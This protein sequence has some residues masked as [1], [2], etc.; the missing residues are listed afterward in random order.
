MRL[1]P[2]SSFHDMRMD[3][4]HAART[5]LRTQSFVVAVLSL[6]LAVGATTAVYVTADWLLNRSPTGV[7]EPERLVG[8][9]LAEHGRPTEVKFGFSYPQYN[10]LREVQDAFS[11]VAAYAKVVRVIGDDDW[12]D[13]VVIQFVSGS[14]FPLLGVRPFLGHLQG[15]EDDLDGAAPLAVLSHAFWRSH[16]GADPDVVGASFR[17]GVDEARIIGV[18]GPDF[19]DYS[20]DWNG[21]TQVWLPMRS[22][23]G[24]AGMAGMLTMNQTFFRVMGRLA[25]G[26]DLFQAGE[27][28]Q[29]WV[30]ELPAVVNSLFDANAIA[31]E[32]EREMRIARRDQAKA[33]LGA[34]FAVN[35]LVLL[36]ACVNVVNL[37]LGR[38]A[39]RKKEMAIRAALGASWT[40]MLRQALTEA[41]LLAV[42]VGCAATGL[43]V[44]L[45]SLLGSLPEVYLDLSNRTDPLTTSGAVDL[46]MVG[47]AVAIGFVA[48][49]VL[50][51]LPMLSTFR[52]PI[53]AIKRCPP[54]WSLSRNRPSLR[55]GLLVLQVGLATVL[56]I[57]GGLFARSSNGA[58]NVD[59]EYAFPESV[60]L[61]RLVPVG[62][63][64]DE[65]APFFHS[66]MDALGDMP[67]VVSAALSHNPPFAGGRS[68]VGLPDDPEGSFA[69]GAATAGPN[70]FETNGIEVLA[71][72]EFTWD[73]SDAQ[74]AVV[75]EVAARRL[76]PREDPVGRVL[77]F[78]GEPARVIGLV[79]RDR[80]QDPLDEPTPCAWRQPRLV[81]GAMTVRIRTA[82]R[83]MDFLP[84]LRQTV[85][86]INP[87]VSIVQGQALGDF[88]ERFVRAEK[89][90]ATLSFS[91][92]LFGIVLLSIGCASVFTSMVRECVRE[93]AIRMALGATRASLMRLVITQGLLLLMAGLAVGLVAARVV[94][95]RVSGQLYHIAPSDPA[96]YI[97]ALMLVVAVS[98]ASMLYPTIQATTES[99]NTHLQEE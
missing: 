25:P 33:F 41:S 30:A 16:F 29:R 87:A 91:I 5:M 2:R 68:T 62:L 88:L 23:Q 47:L 24:I 58:A 84:T 22:A 54:R 76:W 48:S 20:L 96:T 60:L 86:T 21:P 44:W 34:L 77:H 99:P 65:M 72:R 40:R 1:D 43:G 80:C 69:V 12:S 14:Y 89:T 8:L 35:V 67:E 55:Q 50:G 98:V 82:G 73:E 31:I 27:R 95:G 59:P 6:G 36:A 66:L 90:S 71:G 92:A 9:S 63:D 4:A 26:V 19:E 94:A 61:A 70:F 49:L 74:T 32:P 15:P 81:A 52:D 46:K 7:V 28:A 3:A 78:N 79:R 42:A 38:A 57:T 93:I 56:A 45:A 64:R 39:V 17:V 97:S 83:P 10:E 51:V 75:N 85:H 37:L 18:L 11:D 53:S 13:E